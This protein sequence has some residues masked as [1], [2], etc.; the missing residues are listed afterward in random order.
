M[1]P[2]AILNP[3][4]EQAPRRCAYCKN[5]YNLKACFNCYK[6]YYCSK[7]CRLNDQSSHLNQCNWERPSAN[8]RTT[9]IDT[10]Q[11]PS[12]RGEGNHRRPPG[13]PTSSQHSPHP[14][15]STG[16]HPT[17]LTPN[18]IPDTHLPEPFH[19]LSSRTWLHGRD[20]ETTGLLLHD[21]FR[22]RRHLC[23]IHKD[24]VDQFD[25]REDPNIALQNWIRFAANNGLLSPSSDREAY[26]HRL[27]VKAQEIA[28]AVK[29]HGVDGGIAAP[30]DYNN[31][32]DNT[33]APNI[34]DDAFMAARHRDVSMGLQMRAFGVQVMGREA[35]Q[36]GGPPTKTMLQ[37]EALSNNLL[38]W[39]EW[40]RKGFNWRAIFGQ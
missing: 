11:S 18:G 32:N 15:L 12:S 14:P 35:G 28:R 24:S 23:A 30:P 8:H 34:W 29:E 25:L 13:L 26:L 3:V 20:L 22:H 6:V 38:R 16:R 1:A 7:P 21:T 31:T 27:T 2:S 5:E 40:Q 36:S 39:E 37:D 19:A 9:N 4:P 17:V 10:A 33:L